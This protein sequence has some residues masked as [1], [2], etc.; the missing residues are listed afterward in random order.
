MDPLTL[1]IFLAI[2]SGLINLIGQNVEA[3][4]AK[5]EARQDVSEANAELVKAKNL[6][7]G[8]MIAQTAAAGVGGES[9]QASLGRTSTA[10]DDVIKDNQEG[11][12]EFIKNTDLNLA[13]NTVSTVLG[14]GRSIYNSAFNA[15]AFEQPTD[16]LLHGEARTY[17]KSTTGAN[18]SLSV[19]SIP[20]NAR[21]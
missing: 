17:D 5:K 8:S 6:A 10:Y 14:T 19:G 18:I 7:T 9:V 13:F 16:P 20:F 3:T 21:Y 15:G 2:G 11:L 4:S 1:S 12:D